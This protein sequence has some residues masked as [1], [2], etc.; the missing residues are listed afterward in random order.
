[1]Q[2]ERE[3]RFVGPRRGQLL[4]VLT[5]LVLSVLL[6]SQITSQTTWVTK[7]AVFAQPRFWPAVGVGGMVLFTALH[8]WKLPFRRFEHADFREALRW[9]AALE[10]ALWFMGYVTLVPLIGYL[11]VTLVFVLLLSHRM[12]YR[13]RM[14][15]IIGVLFAIAIVVIF[16]GLLAVRIPGAALYEYFPDGLR[17]FAI[18]YL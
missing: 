16:K 11:P 3:R 15:Q 6:L 14:M 13:G 1:M 12:G 18:L 9:G 7:T 2:S 4:F 17:S 10:F 5:F 8:L